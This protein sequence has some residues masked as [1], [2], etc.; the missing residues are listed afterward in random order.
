MNNI[1]KLVCI[2]DEYVANEED[3]LRHFVV[4]INGKRRKLVTYAKGEKGNALRELHT[5]VSKYIRN[6]YKQSPA[7]FAYAKNKNI[8]DCLK[9]H[10]KSSAF[11]KTD[12]HSYFDSITYDGT[13]C[14]LNKYKRYQ[15]NSDKMNVLLKACFYNGRLP[16]GF[17]SSPVIS[18]IFL[19][20][21]DRKYSHRKDVLYTRYADDF[22]ISSTEMNSEIKLKEVC[23]ELK[24]DLQHQD[25]FLNHKKTYIRTLKQNGDAIHLLGVNLVKTDGSDNRITVS[26]RYIRKTCRGLSEL[27]NFSGDSEEKEELFNTVCGQISFIQMCSHDSM[28]KL[29]KMVYV[30]CGYSGSLKTSSIG[31]VCG[32]VK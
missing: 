18:D 1:D 11:L 3:F 24:N 27:L 31:R 15:K 14:V 9:V 7:S 4:V 16:L 20:A 5:Y 26:D 13:Q 17:V 19:V 10:G 25:L 12:I 2:A 23:D 30:K 28:N 29:Q 21:L 22:I 6:L 32:L 8:I